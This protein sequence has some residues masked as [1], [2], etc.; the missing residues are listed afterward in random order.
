MLTFNYRFKSAALTAI[1]I[2]IYSLAAQTPVLAC[3]GGAPL[4]INAL[5]KDSDYVV[6][7]VPVELDDVQQNAI[8]HVESYL[9]GRPG[10]EYLLFVQNSPI[11]S[12]YV[13]EGMTSGADCIGFAPDLIPRRS[14]Y[15]FLHHRDDGSYV[16]AGTPV[17]PFVYQFDSPESTVGIFPESSSTQDQNPQVSKDY[18]DAESGIQVT[19]AEFVRT[20]VEQNGKPST[21]PIADAPYPLYA[22]LILVTTNGTQYELPIDGGKPFKLTSDFSIQRQKL[23]PLWPYGY[24]DAGECTDENCVQYS[25]DNLN[26][27]VQTNENTII[28]RWGTTIAGQASL[29]SPVDTIAVWNNNRL[30]VYSLGYPRFGGS[31][32][33]DNFIKLIGEINLGIPFEAYRKRAAWSPDGRLLAYSDASGLWLW[34]VFDSNKP[35]LMIPKTGGDPVIANNF[36]PMGRY[37]NISIG[38]QKQTLD[39][40]TG[41]TFPDGVV[42]PDDR[43]LLAFGNGELQ[44][45]SFAP[46]HCASIQEIYV[47]VFNETGERT[48]IYLADQGVQKAVWENK[49]HILSFVCAPENLEACVVIRS[50]VQYLGDWWNEQI[51]YGSDFALD[52]ANDVVAVVTHGKTIEIGGTTYDLT[53]SIDSDI[54]TIEWLPSLFY[55][56][57]A[58]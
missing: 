4:T 12:Q 48:A 11:V 28:L 47:W 41:D 18:A 29:F 9:V 20:I 38:E 32:F 43:L 19:E 42:S 35:R 55:R 56:L 23:D 49:Y 8:L 37:L 14:I 58:R 46:Q 5:I 2:T 54:A 33:R 24:D 50:K 57:D 10:P 26:I 34:D 30:Q 16:S 7:A 44:V 3:S 52:P 21:K 51:V 31:P 22:P 1:L 45:C 53:T 15:L 36:S 27:A 25:S 6:K 17:N 13:L 40:L 39:V